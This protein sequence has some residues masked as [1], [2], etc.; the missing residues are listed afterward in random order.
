MDS[1]EQQ[2]QADHSN[3]ATCVHAKCFMILVSKRK[4]SSVYNFMKWCR[5]R[6]LDSRSPGQKY[7]PLM[8]PECS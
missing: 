2:R 3:T 4:F 8:E 1:K 6:E 5:A 7:T